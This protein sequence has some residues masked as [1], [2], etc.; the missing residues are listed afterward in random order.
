MFWHATQDVAWA[1]VCVC[2]SCSSVPLLM[3]LSPN[4]SHAHKQK[5]TTQQEVWRRLALRESVRYNLW[6]RFN[7]RAEPSVY[8]AYRPG[9]CTTT[10]GDGCGCRKT[11]SL[12]GNAPEKLS[13][14][15]CRKNSRSI[16]ETRV[17]YQTVS[18]I[19]IMNFPLYRQIKFYNPVSEIFPSLTTIQ[20]LVWNYDS[21]Q[22]AFPIILIPCAEIMKVRLDWILVYP[23]QDQIPSNLNNKWWKCIKP[24]IKTF[25]RKI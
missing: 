7:L 8:L 9:W 18:K 1:W 12:L 15:I 14:T 22:N 13:K 2:D 20:F 23:N 10:D 16:H 11:R 21:K 4:H 6:Q 5:R 19:S 24:P 25:F 17:W 3:K